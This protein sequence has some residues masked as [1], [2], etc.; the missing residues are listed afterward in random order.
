M[1]LDPLASGLLSILAALVAAG[2]TLYQGLQKQQ[3][4]R[5]KEQ[6][7]QQ[8]ERE[9]EQRLAAQAQAERE[10]ILLEERIRGV[11][12]KCVDLAAKSSAQDVTNARQDETIRHICN[13][14]E[15]IRGDVR[16]VRT[17]V[18]QHPRTTG[19]E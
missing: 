19:S 7:A 17:A 15:E 8:A 14:L 11:E 3:A 9:K 16:D 18:L 13:V 2:G 10:R 4:D 6:R 12:T 1:A 5:E